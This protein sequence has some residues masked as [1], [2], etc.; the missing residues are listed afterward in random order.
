MRVVWRSE[1]TA[2]D[3][4]RRGCVAPWAVGVVD[5]RLG[6]DLNLRLNLDL[7]LNLHLRLRTRLCSAGLT[8]CH[9]VLFVCYE[10]CM[11]VRCGA[12]RLQWWGVAS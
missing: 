7:R 3:V 4:L 10:A 12:V 5:L 6:L 8:C 1:E 11:A 9:I 2:V